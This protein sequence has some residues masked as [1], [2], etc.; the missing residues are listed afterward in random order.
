MKRKR[1]VMRPVPF[2]NGKLRKAQYFK[3]MMRN[4]FFRNGK[5]KENWENFRKS[6][7][8]YVKIRSQSLQHYFNTKCN[9]TQSHNPKAFWDTMKP[10]VTD[11]IKDNSQCTTLNIDGEITTDTRA[12]CDAFNEYFINAAAHIGSDD[13][14]SDNDD[15][16]SILASHS[17]HPSIKTIQER[18]QNYG[19]FNFKMVPMND[20]HKLLK[21]TN[22]R[23]ATGCDRIP[24]KLLKLAADEL[25][26]PVTNL[27]NMSIVHSTF[28]QRMKMAELSPLYKAKDSLERS[29]Y[30]PLSILPA[31]SKLFERIYY[32]QLYAYFHEIFVDMLSAYRPKY[33]CQHV[34]LK[35]IE[36][37]KK[38]LDE[39]EHVGAVLMD[40]SK[41]FDV[42]SHK[43]LLSKMY[44]YGV[45][46]DACTLIFS[47]L[48][49]RHQRV[50]IGPVRSDWV[51]IKKGVPQG[52]ILGP[53]LFNV[54]MNDIF[55][56]IDEN[57]LYNYADDNS[58]SFW[59][60]SLPV[61]ISKLEHNAE[62]SLKWF[63][64]NQM[65]ANPS[66]FQCFLIERNNECRDITLNIADVAVRP[67]ASAKLLG[68]HL[69]SKLNFD[70][71]ISKLCSKAS[72]HISAISRVSKYLDE[73]CRFQLFHAFVRSQFQYCDIIWHFCNKK[74][75]IKLE[76][77]HKRALQITLNDYVSPYSEL[78]RKANVCS[79]Y[80]SRVKNIALEVYKCINKTNPAF[81]HGLFQFNDNR[82]NLR[83]GQKLIQPLVNTETFGQKS[84]RYTGACIWN[85]L[86]TNVKCAPDIKSFKSALDLWP[87]PVCT[88]GYCVLCY[89]QNM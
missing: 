20:V 87:G 23:K 66:K 34:L 38:A 89:V 15:V 49:K 58:L 10:F 55:Y 47:Y 16:E 57:S 51:I 4:R 88:C 82:Y 69:D 80:I 24:P 14:L 25:A 41:A 46:Q 76:K 3:C 74:N 73:N 85:K 71:H 72:R 52:S 22:P 81:L 27:I 43:L 31:I 37:W 48:S 63:T 29:N 7:N 21:S 28:P 50:K 56:S 78:L 11:K 79:L 8:N 33:G 2:M 18:S 60:R 1:A 77:L 75:H 61:V 65:Q 12:I 26:Y 62:T 35:L 30:R 54:F 44:A 39:R 83:D 45:S 59:D 64:D 42:I 17:D 36:D 5:T 68:V 67:E 9:A 84:L 13:Y 53:L 40:L 70:N 6:R 19:T 32:D 86:P